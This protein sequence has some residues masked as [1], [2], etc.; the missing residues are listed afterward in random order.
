MYNCM[1]PTPFSIHRGTIG[2]RHWIG[3]ENCKS[4]KGSVLTFDSFVRSISTS[5]VVS[6]LKRNAIFALTEMFCAKFGG[7]ADFLAAAWRERNILAQRFAR[8]A[9]LD[10]ASPSEG[11]GCGFDPR[12]AHQPSLAQRATARQAIFTSPS[13]NSY[14]LRFALSFG[15]RAIFN[16]LSQIHF[17]GANP[18]PSAPCSFFT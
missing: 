4:V 6:S 14:A 12:R 16:R 13:Q 1:E 9:Q 7:L 2:D 5:I 3:S 8:V 17:S 15:W 11:E 10:R 18:A